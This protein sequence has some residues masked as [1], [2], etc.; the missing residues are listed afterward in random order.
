LTAKRLELCCAKWNRPPAPRGLQI[1]TFNASKS[2][3]I[4][5]RWPQSGAARRRFWCFRQLPRFGQ[6]EPCSPAGT[7]PMPLKTNF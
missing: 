2:R 6:S 1:Q 5:A 4:D 3:E 7:L